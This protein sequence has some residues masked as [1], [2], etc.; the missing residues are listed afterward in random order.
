MRASRAGSI[1]LGFAGVLIILRPGAEAFQP[2]ALLVLACALGFAISLITTKQLTK[3]VSTFAILF[4]MNLMQFPIGLAGSDPFYLARLG[5]EQLPA[6]LGVGISGLASHYCLANAF[7]SGD[8]TV[9]VPLDF[10][11]IPLIALVGWLFYDEGVD[12]LVFAG[13]AV[14]IVG[15][16]WNL[17]DEARR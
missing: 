16:V 6:F 5:V 15:V 3:D 14:I 12:V 8:A 7:R 17:R 10:L 1:V 11:R 2:A 9:V 13:A 4:W